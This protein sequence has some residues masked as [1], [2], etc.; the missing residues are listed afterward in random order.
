[1]KLD[2]VFVLEVVSSGPV[3][4]LSEEEDGRNRQS[5][6]VLGVVGAVCGVKTR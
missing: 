4:V 1:M 5:L 3:V 2:D 6:Y